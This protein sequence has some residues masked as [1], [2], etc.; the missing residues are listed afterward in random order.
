MSPVSH[1]LKKWTCTGTWNFALITLRPLHSNTTRIS[2]LNHYTMSLSLLYNSTYARKW[3]KNALIRSATTA[4]SVGSDIGPDLFEVLCL[5]VDNDKKILCKLDNTSIAT[6]SP[7]CV[8]QSSTRRG[9][10]C[11]FLT[12]NYMYVLACSGL[13]NFLSPNH[14]V[15]HGSSQG[16]KKHRDRPIPIHSH[17]YKFVYCSLWWLKSGVVH[18]K[19]TNSHWFV[20]TISHLK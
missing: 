4:F 9:R 3:L 15:L 5:N 18:I 19:Q 20:V 1:P 13:K 6:K 17:E 8:I 16:Q 10:W 11:N 14:C 2:W 7:C 12:Y